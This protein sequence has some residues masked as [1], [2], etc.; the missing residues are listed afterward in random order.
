MTAMSRAG[1]GRERPVLLPMLSVL[2][3]LAILHIQQGARPIP[4]TVMLDALLS[5]D[6]DAF[7]HF[8]ILSLRLPRAIACIVAGAALGAAG[9]LLQVAMR[10]RLA[11]PH[12]LGLNAG[13]SLAVVLVTTHQPVGLPDILMPLAA[14]LGAAGLFGL[15]L[16]L[17]AV[18]SGR[19]DPVRMVF[20]GIA[21]SAL[22]SA[23]VS[24]ILILNEDTLEQLRFWLVGDAAGVGAAAIW[25]TL[26]AVALG[27][28]AGGLLMPQLATFSLGESISVALGASV[29][30][31]RVAA[32]VVTA[33]LCG[34]A[35]S[36]VGPIGFV[37]LMAPALWPRLHQRPS[38]GAFLLVAGSGAAIL[39]AADILALGLLAP[40]ELPT[41]ALTGL[42][43]APVFI[44]LVARRLT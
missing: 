28:V 4:A 23:L 1:H 39:L 19:F 44:W 20:F 35:V 21:L 34:S 27:L 17:S 18:G 37:G 33:L 6:R 25:S 36:L 30:K 2:A 8:V 29:R 9:F 24:A 40:T 13:A 41:G 14:S 10:N 38:L 3:V 31:T 42:A 7:D 11:E 43:G 22:A 16:A 32:L 15:V 26:P 5:P 12:V